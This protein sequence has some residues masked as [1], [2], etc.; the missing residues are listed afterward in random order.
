MDPYGNQEGSTSC[1]KKPN[2]GGSIGTATK[3]VI[4]ILAP[5]IEVLGQ[6]AQEI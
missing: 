6:I 5:T 1:L 4:A 3:R 2:H